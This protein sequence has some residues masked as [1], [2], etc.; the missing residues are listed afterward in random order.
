MSSS[1]SSSGGGGAG[2]GQGQAQHKHHKSHRRGQQGGR[3]AL[4]DPA[5]LHQK[6]RGHKASHNK[7]AGR[8]GLGDTFNF[9]PIAGPAAC[10]LNLPV[11]Q[12]CQCPPLKS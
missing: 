7:M 9:H 5:S 12:S 1:H 2:Q 6:G 10:T 11:F 8:G 3:S 4:P